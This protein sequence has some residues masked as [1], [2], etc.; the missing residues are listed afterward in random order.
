MNELERG[1][2]GE[3]EESQTL[4]HKGCT[5]IEIPFFFWG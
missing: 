1:R 4:S 2:E 3:R 5:R